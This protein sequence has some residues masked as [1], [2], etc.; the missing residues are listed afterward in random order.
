[1]G[2]ERVVEGECGQIHRY[3]FKKPV[4]VGECIWKTGSEVWEKGVIRKGSE[5]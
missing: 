1:M 2:S 3:F 5:G 4:K